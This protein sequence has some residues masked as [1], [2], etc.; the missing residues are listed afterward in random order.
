MDTSDT[1]GNLGVHI[2]ETLSLEQQIKEVVKSCRFHMHA[3]WQIRPYLTQY[4]AK[5]LVHA[6][7]ISRLDYCNSL[8]VN[9]PMK[10]INKLQKV[11]NEAARLVT[12]TPRSDHITPVL[13]SLH[14]LPIKQR[15][16]FKVLTVVY[17]SIN[18]NSPDYIRSLLTRYEPT[19]TLRS[20]DQNR[21]TEP[22][23]RLKSAGYRSF[24][25][26]APRLWNKLPL[27]IRNSKSITV[28]KKVLKTYL[29][30]KAYL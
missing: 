22:R 3:L 26:A 1:V 14:W 5:L 29:F 19:R 11:M 16:E 9:M 13:K 27:E 8:Y 15:I 7:I 23:F 17:N 20:S 28:F 24:S 25:V 18:G 6:S 12:Y 4:N 10:Q 2:D 30:S 21:L